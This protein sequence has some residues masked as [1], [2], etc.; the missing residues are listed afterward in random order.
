MRLGVLAYEM[1]AGEPGPFETDEV[2][3]N[4]PSR[5]RLFAA[6]T[7]SQERVAAL[8]GPNPKPHPTLTLP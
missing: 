6:A 8:R 2:G 5:L 3:D 1:L 7:T 4:A